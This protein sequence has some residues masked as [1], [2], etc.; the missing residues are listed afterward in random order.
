M[1]RFLD[2]FQT[3]LTDTV[4]HAEVDEVVKNAELEI[5]SLAKHTYSA[6]HY[7]WARKA[8]SAQ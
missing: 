6:W 5:Q 7:S 8:E 1:R 4:S 2:H 3:A